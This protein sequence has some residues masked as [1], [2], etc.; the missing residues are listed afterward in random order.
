MIDYIEIVKWLGAIA[1]AVCGWLWRDLSTIRR[2]LSEQKAANA[3]LR[4]HVAETYVS[5]NDLNQ[6]MDRVYDSLT[7]IEK[8]LD[9]K[10]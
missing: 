9:E 5:K 7:R 4:A 3:A 1:I 6:L 2:D 8:K 10:K